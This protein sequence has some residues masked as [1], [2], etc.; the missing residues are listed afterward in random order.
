[1]DD[2]REKIRL[3]SEALLLILIGVDAFALTV[4]VFLPVKPGTFS[5]II[6]LDLLTSLILAAAYLLRRNF[7]SRSLNILVVAV[8]FYFIGFSI[9]GMAQYSPLLRLLN[10]IKVIGLSIALVQLAGSLGEFLRRSRLSYGLGFFMGSLF[11]FTVIFYLAESPVNPSV[12][13]YED[14]LWYV[15]QTLTTVG[16]GDIIPVTFPGRLAGILLMLSAIATTSLVTASA[17]STLMEKIGEEQERMM[18]ERKEAFR[19]LEKRI[20]ELEGR[21]ERIEKL[22]R[23]LVDIMK[24][25]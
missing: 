17:T 4:T 13:T 20:D 11:L 19:L 21:L 12:S 5:N 15:L 6:V 25:D 22:T 23:D 3:L 24:K 2:L 9:L 10:F 16:Y 8:P 18:S 7:T 14:S 1:M